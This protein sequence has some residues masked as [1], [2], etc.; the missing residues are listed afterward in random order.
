MFI[1][2]GHYPWSYRVCQLGS[3]LL[4]NAIKGLTYLGE[5]EHLAILSGYHNALMHLP[6]AVSDP[7]LPTTL[8]VYWRLLRSLGQYEELE[9]RQCQTL[10]WIRNQDATM[11]VRRLLLILSMTEAWL[12][13]GKQ[14][15]AYPV[16]DEVR[17]HLLYRADTLSTKNG[18]RAQVACRYIDAL[19]FASL[20]VINE[21]I[22]E[23]LEQL[24]R[25][26]N[27]TIISMYFC[28][29]ALQIVEAIAT[30]QLELN[31]PHCHVVQPARAT[32]PITFWP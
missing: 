8:T 2:L 13:L 27:T 20:D 4:Q 31:A 21:R 19:A 7:G 28:L 32:T 10:D 30:C 24:E 29:P 22:E 3:A 25:P 6:Q 12:M 15:Q 1:G 23:M 16:L 11:S 5:I 9:R 18:E 17:E 14:M 26:T